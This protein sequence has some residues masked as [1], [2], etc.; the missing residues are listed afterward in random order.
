MCIHFWKDMNEPANFDTNGERPWNWP[1]KDKPYWSLKCLLD[2]NTLDIPK[3]KPSKY[4]LATSSIIC[5]SLICFL[6]IWMSQQIL[7]Q[8][9]CELIT[10]QKKISHIGPWNALLTKMSGTI[11]HLNHV[12]ILT[13]YLPTYPV[14]H[15]QSFN[16]IILTSI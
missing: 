2:N 3:Y 6:R 5:Y 16:P 13:L 14:I 8:I 12:W 1:E 11:H 4:E 10:G 15:P 7:R 9:N